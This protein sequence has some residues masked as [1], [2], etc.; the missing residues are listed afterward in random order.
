MPLIALDWGT[1]SL[2]AYLL[3]GAGQVLEKK[4]A[5]LGILN[6][7]DNDFDAAFEHTCGSWLAN[8]LQAA[9][10]LASGM[11]GSR[12]GWVEA[13]Y[14]PCP[15]NAKQL[16]S[17][18]AQVIT[19]KQRKLAIVPGITTENSDD[20]PDVI[21]GEETQIFGALQSG[22]SSRHLFVLPGTHCKW[23]VVESGQIT[24]F[25]TFMTGEIFAALCDHT[26]LGRTMAGKIDDPAAFRRGVEFAVNSGDN[27][28]GLLHQ[29]FSARTLALFNK[30]PGEAL[31]AYLS[32][33]LIGS[34]L[35]D[36]TR[37]FGQQDPIMIIA[38]AALANRYQRAF[39]FMQRNAT[40]AP[41]NVTPRG[42]YFLAQSSGMI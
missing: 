11:I 28:G 16:A 18:F 12:Q 1:T 13:A 27:S 15:A 22:D 30:M 25:A 31:Y 20:V 6:I 42:L 36:A 38:E 4:S 8:G 39:G 26:I 32:G 33:L 19:K 40:I 21:R 37:L 3:D 23:A 10:I 29:L 17:H 41:D 7:P 34:E 5:P 24:H 2:R 9:P 35:R 14:V